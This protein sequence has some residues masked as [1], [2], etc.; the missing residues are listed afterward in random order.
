M[1]ARGASPRRPHARP[2]SAIFVLPVVRIGRLPARRR[3]PRR[4]AR[5]EMR[6]DPAD[7]SQSVARRRLAAA[8]LEQRTAVVLAEPVAEIARGQAD[9]APQFGAVLAVAE[10]EIGIAHMLRRRFHIAWQPTIMAGDDDIVLIFR[11]VLRH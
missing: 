3:Y 11:L 6:L 10:V 1:A 5:R 2:G 9:P 7:P 8:R 4:A